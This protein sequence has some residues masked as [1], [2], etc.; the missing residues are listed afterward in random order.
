MGD[1]GHAKIAPSTSVA[2]PKLCTPLKLPKI[3]PESPQNPSSPPQTPPPPQTA[4]QILPALPNHHP[5]LPNPPKALP[6]PRNIP[7]CPP[8]SSS[9]PILPFNTPPQP[10]HLGV[11]VMGP[12]G[13]PGSPSRVRRMAPTPPGDAPKSGP[14]C[15]EG[16][17]GG[18]SRSPT[19]PPGGSSWPLQPPRTSLPKPTLPAPKQPLWLPKEPL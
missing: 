7:Q 4:P 16:G 1:S 3:P 9:P 10:P 15:G 14:P 17:S 13:S 2:P 19:D 18:A 12:G 5:T 6:A 11:G 8:I